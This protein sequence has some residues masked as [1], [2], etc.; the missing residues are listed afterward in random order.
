LRRLSPE[1]RSV[2]VLHH[3]LGYA[4]AE[5]AELLKVPVGTAQSQ[6]ARAM[7]ELRAEPGAAR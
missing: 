3:W 7:A 6:L 4:L 2:V 1:R 5:T